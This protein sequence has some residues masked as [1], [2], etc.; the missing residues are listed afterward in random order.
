MDKVG[1]S[2]TVPAKHKQDQYETRYSP[3]S[4]HLSFG[5]IQLPRKLYISIQDRSISGDARAF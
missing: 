2:P 5:M 4:M 3:S 1:S